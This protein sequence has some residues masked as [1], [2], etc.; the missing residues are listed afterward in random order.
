M[1]ALAQ[2]EETDPILYT[3]PSCSETFPVNI[4]CYDTE[5]TALNTSK[6]KIIEL[7]LQDISGNN[8]FTEL[9]D[10]LETIE[11]SHIHHITNELIAE[12]NGETFDN[13]APKIEDW[14]EKVYGN[15][16]IVYMLAH[17]NIFYDKMVLESEYARHGLKIPSNWLFIDS[18]QQIR[19]IFPK[20]GRGNYKLSS[21]Y[22]K[23]V[24]KPIVN[25]HRA[26][27]D[28]EALSVV[29]DEMILKRYKNNYYEWLNSGP[30]IEK[31][32][33]SDDY[34]DQKISDMPFG[35]F[36]SELIKLKRKNVKTLGDIVK[37]YMLSDKNPNILTTKYG[38]AKFSSGRILRK[39][40]HFLRIIAK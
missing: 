38:L 31:S 37:I 22:E 8:K 1:A 25:A 32:I 5:T 9:V 6:A 18:Y 24:Q 26:E 11:N 35:L 3:S 13:I 33:F 39:I 12:N 30:F 4:C 21:L 36:Q 29:Y 14:V 2:K 27:A 23:C 40:T 34:L 15:D 28:T 10:P 20:L 7:A 17:N 19:E 16:R